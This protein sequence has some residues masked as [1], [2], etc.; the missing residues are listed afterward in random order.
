[1]SDGICESCKYLRSSECRKNPPTLISIHPTKMDV[2]TSDV[3]QYTRHRAVWPTVAMHN[4]CGEYQPRKHY[5]GES[6]K[7]KALAD[8]AIGL[9]ELVYVGDGKVVCPPA[10]APHIRTIVDALKPY[11]KEPAAE[12]KHCGDCDRPT[13][14]HANWC[15]AQ[16]LE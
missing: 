6:G 2:M 9:V 4:W 3:P 13:N 15:R 11:S 7:D 14:Q 8:A 12:P 16:E 10:F 1:M 5:L